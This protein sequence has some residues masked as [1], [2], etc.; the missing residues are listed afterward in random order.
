MATMARLALK[1]PNYCYRPTSSSPSA[2]EARAVIPSE[3]GATYRDDEEARETKWK[4]AKALMEYNPRLEVFKVAHGEV[5]ELM[6]ISKE[7]AKAQWNE[8]NAPE[9]DPAI[10]PNIY[11]DHVS[12][13]IPFWYTRKEADRVFEQLT[14][15]LQVIRRA[16]G[17]LA[18][19]PQ[20]DGAFDP[21]K[22]NFGEHLEY[23]RIAENRPRSLPKAWQKKKNLGGNSGNEPSPVHSLQTPVRVPV[24]DKVACSETVQKS[25]ALS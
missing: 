19:D 12:L 16:A 10:Q 11:W 9:G 5:A 1:I 23:D 4:I 3:E 22:E 14:A 7:Q 8:L 24:L 20:T 2:D 15:Y 6:K 17:F 13:T 25:G 18:Y 21:D